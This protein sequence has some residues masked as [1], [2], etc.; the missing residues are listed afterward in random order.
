MTEIRHRFSK[1]FS[2]ELPIFKAALGL[3]EVSSPAVN[4]IHE[5]VFAAGCMS[6]QQSGDN[7]VPYWLV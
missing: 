7:T 4:T 2:R 5:S 3:L 6:G 1:E